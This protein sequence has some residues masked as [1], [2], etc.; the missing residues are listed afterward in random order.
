[1]KPKTH[2]NQINKDETQRANI[3]SSKGKATTHKRIPIMITADLSIELFRPEGN[4][5]TY[6]K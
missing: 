3:K 2:T 4:G 5:R 6:L 1:M